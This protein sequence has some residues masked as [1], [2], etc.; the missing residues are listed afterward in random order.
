MTE[1][2][3]DH[4]RLDVY[5]PAIQYMAKSFGLA[6]KLSGLHRR[7]RDQ[8]L[9]AARSIPLNIAEGNGRRES[10]SAGGPG[11]WLGRSADRRKS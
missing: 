8:W 4:D 7:A 5:R 6:K 11:R 9:R 10:G 3:F 1:I 2:M